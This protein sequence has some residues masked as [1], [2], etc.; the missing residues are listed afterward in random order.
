MYVCNDLGEFCTC[1]DTLQFT[2]CV[3]C[4][5]HLMAYYVNNK[6]DNTQ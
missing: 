4:Y 2:K 3:V 5:G 6:A 1:S